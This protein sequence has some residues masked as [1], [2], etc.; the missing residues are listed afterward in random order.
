MPHAAHHFVSPQTSPGWSFASCS[1]GAAT[2]WP[3][4]QVRLLGWVHLRSSMQVT[5]PDS[6]IDDS[7]VVVTVC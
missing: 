5:R 7:L 3:S 2:V 1:N 4:T 6:R